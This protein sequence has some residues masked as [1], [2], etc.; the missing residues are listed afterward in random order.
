MSKYNAPI[1]D[2]I[3]SFE[4][5]TDQREELLRQILGAAGKD[6]FIEP[7]LMVD[8]GCNIKVGENFYANFK[9]AC[10]QS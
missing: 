10:S 4:D 8:H 1:A 6:A 7:P 2:D 5:L 9:Y 3:S